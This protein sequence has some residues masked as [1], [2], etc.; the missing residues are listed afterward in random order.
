M[1]LLEE[2]AFE[3]LYEGGVGELVVYFSEV[4]VGLHFIY[5][6]EYCWALSERQRRK[7]AEE[8]FFFFCWRVCIIIW[9]CISVG[10]RNPAIPSISYASSST[11]V[12]P[13]PSPSP[14]FNNSTAILPCTLA[15]GSS[16][17]RP[18]AKAVLPTTCGPS[19]KNS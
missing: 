2:Q 7:N 13:H 11:T 3:G 10:L 6:W 16:S 5:D 17:S 8:C 18:P 15:F 4:F 19:G 9:S 14:Q 12:R 1:R